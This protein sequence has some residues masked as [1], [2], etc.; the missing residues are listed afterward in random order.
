MREA[1]GASFAES[2]IA[3]LVSRLEAI[4]NGGAQIGTAVA[5]DPAVR[6]FGY[7]KQAT[8]VA[9]FEPGTLRVLRVYFKGQNWRQAPR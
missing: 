9:R 5:D 3:K 8:I 1:R 4:A 2:S 6:A 7:A